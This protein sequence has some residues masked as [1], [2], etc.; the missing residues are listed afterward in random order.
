MHM[1][2]LRSE[3]NGRPPYSFYGRS[4]DQRAPCDSYFFNN[5]GVSVS[6]GRPD[7]LAE[8]HGGMAGPAT[9]TRSVSL[10]EAL[11]GLP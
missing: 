5:V 7:E 11:S 8:F 10:K 1:P 6:F 9:T 3:K 2:L 4:Q